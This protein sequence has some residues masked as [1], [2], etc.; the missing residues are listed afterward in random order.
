MCLAGG[1]ADLVVPQ[2]VQGLN[3]NLCL[4]QK[5]IRFERV[6][7]HMTA[8][9]PESALTRTPELQ[10][11]RR[12]CRGR[13]VLPSQPPLCPGLHPLR[14]RRDAAP[15][16]API[17]PSPSF[18]A[19][20]L[21]NIPQY[22]NFSSAA[23]LKKK[24]KNPHSFDSNPSPAITPLLSEVAR[25][26]PRSS[27]CYSHLLTLH[28]LFDSRRQLPH[29]QS[30]ETALVQATGDLHSPNPMD[31]SLSSTLKSIRQVD[32]SD[33]QMLSSLG[34]PDIPSRSPTETTG[35]IAVSSAASLIRLDLTSGAFRVSL[36]SQFVIP[37]CPF[38]GSLMPPRASLSD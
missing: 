18:S 14:L 31:T 6:H 17:S 37:K 34:R 30:A 25:L 9:S 28:S 3:S 29:Q 21:K 35:L 15:P 11:C 10:S 8:R 33:G 23:Q 2:W 36:F 4:R 12:E 38:L 16:V 32:S 7:C 5:F 24:K 22:A 19:S 13:G 20:L 27:T 1:V 26:S